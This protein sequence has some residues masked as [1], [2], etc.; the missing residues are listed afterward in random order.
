MSSG[1][2]HLFPPT[3]TEE[4]L[5]LNPAA[6]EWMMGLPSGHV[7]E[8]PG[9]SRSEQLKCIGNGVVPQ[10]AALAIRTLLDIETPPSA[11]YKPS[12]GGVVTD[13]TESLID[14]LDTDELRERFAN[15]HCAP[16]CDSECECAIIWRLCDLLD[17]ARARP[18]E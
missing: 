2:Q 15:A 12:L 6:A 8:C 17:E 4:Y 13:D 5:T 14:S 10:H 11:G 9:V 18:T 16:E 1:V 3:N 7:T